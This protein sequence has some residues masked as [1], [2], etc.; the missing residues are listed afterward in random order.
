[1]SEPIVSNFPAYLDLRNR[2]CL[3]V[4]G[5]KVAYHKANILKDY[6]SLIRVVSL[7]FIP[8]FEKISSHI[9]LIQRE[10]K[11]Q[12][13]E[14]IALAVSAAGNPKVDFRLKEECEKRNILLNVVDQP[15]LCSF[16]FPAMIQDG[17]LNI[18][19]STNG[20][21]PSAAQFLKRVIRTDI[22]ADFSAKLAWLKAC[23]LAVIS[24]IGNEK[25]RSRLFRFLFEQALSCAELPSSDQLE[26]WISEASQDAEAVFSESRPHVILAGAGCGGVQQ[27]TLE[28]RDLIVNAPVIFYDDL[29][30]PEIL[31]LASGELIYVGK[32]KSRHSMKQDQISSLLLEASRKYPWVLRL[33]GG[34]PYVFGRGMEEKLFLEKHGVKVDVYSGI[35]SP[36][37]VAARMNIPVTDRNTARSFMVVSAATKDKSVLFSEDISL[38]AHY[39]GT[40]IILMGFTRIKEICDVLIK[41]GKNPDSLAAAISSPDIVSSLGVRSTLK[42]LPEAVKKAGL[43][44]PGILII[45][46]SVAYMKESDDLKEEKLDWNHLPHSL[47]KPLLGICATRAFEDRMR[48]NLSQEAETETVLQGIIAPEP[49]QTIDTEILSLLKETEA[50]KLNH[51]VFAFLSENGSRIFIECLK[52]TKTDLRKLAAVRIACI[53]KRTA[54]PFEKAGIQPDQIAERSVSSAFAAEIN[55]NVEENTPIISFRCLQASDAF[56]NSLKGSHPVVRINLYSID[57]IDGQGLKNIAG[58]NG[59]IFGSPESVH[60]LIREISGMQEAVREKLFALPVFCLSE[61]TGQVLSEAGFRKIHQSEEVSAQGLASLV[62]KSFGLKGK[63]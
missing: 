31:N 32:R 9:Q 57:W 14:G 5:G 29:L 40:L 6:C 13:L 12:D 27:L 56:E 50:G 30:D 21:S 48:N 39:S 51:P 10:F 53:G 24:K 52:R 4:G 22:P 42:N 49:D 54:E 47:Q 26:K 1:M 23:R 33:K 61:T 17:L 16:I 41:A 19:I 28:V 36:V 63:D 45:S 15:D 34:D 2:S 62:K 18:A 55:S 60:A 58:L 35:S 7:E 46:P 3:I 44:P 59:L 37:A 25:N 20:A 8:D 11:I 43:V 38:L